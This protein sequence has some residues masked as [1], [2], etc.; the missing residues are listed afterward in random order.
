MLFWIGGVLRQ[1][2]NRMSKKIGKQSPS[3][4]PAGKKTKGLKNPATT[5]SSSDRSIGQRSIRTKTV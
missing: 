1:K 2:T 5:K 3:D 4:H